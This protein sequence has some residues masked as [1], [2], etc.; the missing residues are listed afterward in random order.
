MGG[1]Q[2][3]RRN[4]CASKSSASTIIAE[5]VGVGDLRAS[6]DDLN[7]TSER[8]AIAV[9][10]LINPTVDGGT[11]NG[12]LPVGVSQP[13]KS[14]ARGLA[15]K[16]LKVLVK[17]IPRIRRQWALRNFLQRCSPFGTTRFER[18]LC[19]KS[20]DEQNAKHCIPLAGRV[21]PLYSARRAVC[22]AQ[23]ISLPVTCGAARASRLVK[24]RFF[25][26]GRVASTFG[27]A[28]PQDGKANRGTSGHQRVR[29]VC[30]PLEGISP[31]GR[32]ITCGDRL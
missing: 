19:S 12:H 10:R 17:D 7:R 20:G 9:R 22:P 27:C 31:R 6:H 11:C 15:S 26:V 13:I 28:V 24:A 32:T 25:M 14:K 16:F 5:V 1:L 29:T 23:G 3:E 21:E 18:R 4:E 30:G 2:S 8:R